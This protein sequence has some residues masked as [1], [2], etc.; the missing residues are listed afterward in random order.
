M[1]EFIARLGLIALNDSQVSGSLRVTN[2]ITGSLFGTASWAQNAVSSSYVLNAVTASFSSQSISASFAS[3]SSLSTR[4]VITASAVGSTITFTKGDNSTFGVT[5]T[6]ANADTASY[7]LS[8]NVDG[9]LG[10]NSVLS[11]SLALTASSADN[12]TVRGTLTAQT[13]VA[14]VIT[15]STDF[16]TGSTRFGSLLTNT[17][18]FTGS[19]GMTGSLSVFGNVGIGTTSPSAR[20]HITGSTNPILRI[21]SQDGSDTTPTV[22]IE[23]NRGL[24]S[25]ATATLVELRANDDFRGRGIHMTVSGS[26]TKWFAGVPYTGNGYSIGY[27][28]S[29]NG[30][31]WYAASSSLF[32]NTSRN[33]G[34]GT[35]S[36]TR[37]VQVNVSPAAG[38]NDDGISVNNG[39]N[40]FLF[41]R[42]GVGYTY[43]DVP[44][45]AGLIYATTNIAILADVSPS[46]ISFHT[47]G[48]ERMR[49]AVNGNVGIGTTSPVA[50]FNVVSAAGTIARYDGSGV[51]ASSATEIDILGPQS[52]GELNVGVGGSTFTDSTN[53]IQNKA[54]I[55]AG[56]GLTGLNLRSDAGYVQIT[57]GGIAASNEVA[58]FTSGGNVGIGTTS[59]N[60]KLDVNGNAIITGSLTVT[61]GITGS[62]FG[63]SSFSST[64]SLPIRG[65]ITA[66]AAGSTVTFTKGDNSQFS[67]TLTT[68]TAETASFVLSSNVDGPLGKNSVLSASF[69]VS[70]SRAIT[71]LS[72]SFSV[73][74]SL[75]NAALTS[76]SASFAST[77]SLSTRSIIT[78]SAAGSTITFTK[79]DNSQFSVVINSTSAE[80]ASYVLASNVDGPLGKN[81][82]LSS[83]NA[84]TASYVLNAVSSSFSTS[85]SRALSAV[86]SSFALTASSADNFTVRGTLT[87]QTIVAQVITSSTD[88]VT[89]S[90]RFGSALSNT[91]AFTGS[92]SITGSTTMFGTVTV[93][94]NG[95]GRTISTYYGPGS[96]GEN[97]FIGGGGLSSGTGGGGSGNGS[98]NSAMGVDALLSNTTGYENSAVGWYA[99]RLN[100]TGYSNSA[101]GAKALSN[102][103][104]GFN[105]SAVGYDALLSNTTGFANSAFGFNA[106]RSNTTGFDNAAIGL[107]SLSSNTTGFGNCAVGIDAGRFINSG[108]AN[109]TSFNSVYI[110]Y[111]ARASANGN[112]NEVVIGFS[113]RGNG[114]NTATYGNSSMVKHIFPAGNL[115]IGTTTPNARL[116]VNGNAIVTGSLTVT[117]GITGSLFG[118]SSWANNS[119]SASFAVS[120]AWAP[121]AGTTVFPFTGSAL[122]TGS[123]SLTGSYSITG[124]VTASSF[125]ITDRTGSTQY[126]YGYL[127]TAASSANVISSVPTGSFRAAFYNYVATSGSNARA[128]QISSVWFSTTCSFAEYITTDIGSTAQVDMYVR[129]NEGF[130]Q[131]VASSS[132]NWIIDTSVNLV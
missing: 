73:S 50:K 92:V 111:D 57:A 41:T 85:A 72:S 98:R 87:A 126:T 16:V 39:T 5:L 120:A 59:P 62:I 80:S 95:Q 44:A 128:G 71:S 74:S 78:A 99:L 46:N 32:I 17:H 14:Q 24:G 107:S 76:T 131:L 38:N 25:P 94:T 63:S 27:D 114:T 30:L 108:G 18:A 88:F 115:G 29:S 82:V 122:F 119:I 40:S 48:G 123:M 100:S 23:G 65:I 21:E 2:G 75:A 113:A 121:S 52:N 118:T 93:N 84:L 3:T 26:N 22:Y 86:T 28:A 34:I 13:V 67:V 106:L 91:H 53:N 125:V 4:S 15:S 61:Q 43:R 79:G 81:S 20:L 8:S 49:I 97:I 47:S 45:E 56:S 64:S 129:I 130:V 116:D 101:L 37:K 68:A 103:T 10:R 127:S 83:S 104:E 90:T 31:P 19:I 6:T 7:V 89:G 35:T 58:R 11:S 33:V 96:T 70:S 124:S 77:S 9:P 12:F 66:S 112:G 36:P 60:A 132:A 42:T 54:F 105:N 109:Q 51:A 110:G 55:T 1:G 117:Q 69:T 102:N